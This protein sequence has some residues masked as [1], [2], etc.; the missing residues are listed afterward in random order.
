M[1]ASPMDLVPLWAFFATTLGVVFVAIEAGFRIGRRRAAADDPEKESAVGVMSS[2]SLALLAF[3]LA[4]TFGFA[5]SRIEKRRTVLTDE[6]N[7]IGTLH[8]RTDFLP[9]PQRDQARDLLREYVDVRLEGAASGRL[10]AVVARSVAIQSALWAQV[11]DLAA[12]GQATIP[13]GLYVQALNAVIDL[14]TMRLTENVRVRVPGAVWVVLF[15]ITVLA[16]VEMGYQTG[17]GGRRR[18][19]STPAFALAFS[20]VMLLIVDL[21]RPGEGWI[22][23]GQESMI[24]LR[25]SMDAPPRRARVQGADPDVVEAPSER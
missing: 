4:F 12:R 15:A 21:D 22:R 25:Q 13:F 14:H 19:L 6:V 2:A 23:V 20:S 3:L 1:Y 7:A 8:L 18:P 17:L 11:T 24:E 10:D 5:A 16:M 9:E